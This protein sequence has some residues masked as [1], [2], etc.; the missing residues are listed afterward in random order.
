MMPS[1]WMSAGLVVLVLS[2]AGCGDDGGSITPPPPPPAISAEALD[3]VS[4]D[5]QKAG[6]GLPLVSPLRVRVIGS[7]D[8]PLAG[9]TVGWSVTQG[10]ATLN[11]LESTT[12]ASGEAETWVT[13]GSTVEAVTITATVAELTP[14]TFSLTAL[15]PRSFISV[16][17]GFG[18]TCAVTATGDAYCWGTNT[19]GNLGNGSFEE[20]ERPMLVTGG[21]Q[22]AQI[23]A[24][25]HDTCGLTTEGTAYCWGIQEDGASDQTS[26][27]PVLGA[28]TFVSVSVG[29]ANH[30]R[31]ALTA[32]GSAYCWGSN[33]SG[34]LGD[35]TTITRLSPVPVAGGL[36]FTDLG[37][38]NHT[39]CGLTT[40][41]LAYC[42]G[43]GEIGVLGTG[44]KDR[45]L[46]PVP[47]A[48]D[49]HLVSLAFSAINTCGTTSAGA[50]YCWGYNA[51]GE[52]GIGSV[53]GPD[54]CEPGLYP[55]SLL[56]LP[57]AGG[58]SFARLSD[59]ITNSHICGLTAAGVAYCWGMNS[60]GQLGTG[61]TG[62]NGLCYP[63]GPNF[64]ARPCNTVPTPVSG[65]LT[66][67]QL[68]TGSA[69]TCGLTPDGAIYCWGS[70][71]GWQLGSSNGDHSYTPVRVTLE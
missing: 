12:D 26:P 48:G 7:D 65:G 59:G 21:L 9:A 67:V 53:D 58:L 22:F 69:H 31:C 40:E 5:G 30:H 25:G 14:A 34:E 4:G 42:W 62:G 6:I 32:D 47:V 63:G 55:C 64:P 24:G 11:P 38:G 28:I 43:M 1:H 52:L 8:Q 19:H 10:H 54:R 15:D 57:V 33:F 37:A 68:S 23:A 45:A 56:P 51:E 2:I 71:E 35:G 27:V 17:A 41:G 13:L 39:S 70:N 16:S 66:F 49:L 36:K 50:A 44:N 60:S 20:P 46:S 61:T 29:G 3:I 18:H